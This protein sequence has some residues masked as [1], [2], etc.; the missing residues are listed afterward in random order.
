MAYKAGRAGGP[1]EVTTKQTLSTIAQHLRDERE[2]ADL[3]QNELAAKSGVP[4]TTIS[5][6]EL[7]NTSPNVDTLERLV[8]GLDIEL[9]QL[10]D[11]QPKARKPK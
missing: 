1:D 4:V 8:L 11:G 9:A 3:S 6:I 2:K 5:R 10:F 7:C